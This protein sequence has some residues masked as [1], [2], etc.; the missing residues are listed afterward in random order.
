[1]AE[2][3]YGLDVKCEVSQQFASDA[4]LNNSLVKFCEMCPQRL[5]AIDKAVS[6]GF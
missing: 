3:I 6:T 2:C 5:K 4:E 1:M